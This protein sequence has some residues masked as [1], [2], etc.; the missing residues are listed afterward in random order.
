MT[1]T[2]LFLAVAGDDRSTDALLGTREG[3]VLGRATGGPIDPR[4]LGVRR[5]LY[6][7][8]DLLAAVAESA[9]CD[10]PREVAQLSV[11]L[12]GVDRPFG[13]RE[14][15][16]ELGSRKWARRTDA[17]PEAFALLHAGTDRGSGVAVL[18]DTAMS[19]VGMAPG[20]ASARFCALGELSGTWGGREDLGRSVLLHAAR[21][22]DGVGP[23]TALAAAVPRQYA[24]RSVAEVAR[25][26]HRGILSRAALAELVPPLFE[27]ASVG[28]AVAR[29]IL[30]RQAAEVAA[31]GLAVLRR[32]DLLDRPV[33]VLLGGSVLTVRHPYLEQRIECA[34]GAAPL[35]SL[36]HVALPRVVGAA[37]HALRGL[38]REDGAQQDARELLLRQVELSGAAFRVPSAAG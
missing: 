38:H 8:A 31:A 11:F 37:F 27:A 32:L 24:R 4:A 14:F 20:G 36:R 28:D 34:F 33:D 21:A 29:S 1:R 22:E 12:P 26:V 17:A 23:G 35:V 3:I 15:Q 6:L 7:L 5:S 25:A 9:G 30:D 19:C 2:T 10:R 13:E 18:C 16:R